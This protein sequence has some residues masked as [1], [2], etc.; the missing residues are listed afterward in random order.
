MSSKVKHAPSRPRAL[1]AAADPELHQP[2]RLYASLVNSLGG[3]VW[4]ADGRTFQFSFVSPQAEEILGY[5]VAQ[6]L[7][8]PDFWV[9]HTYPEDVERCVAFCLEATARGADHKFEYRMIAADGR[10][11]WLHD[12]VTVHT[13]PDGALRLRGIMIDIT[14]RKRVEQ[15]HDERLRF[16]T[17]LTELSATFAH[18]PAHA[19]D[20]EIDRWLRRLIDFLGVDRATL[21]QIG[22]DGQFQRTHTYTAPGIESLPAAPF[23]EQFPWIAEQLRQGHTI[24]WAR[25]PADLPPEARAERRYALKVGAKS[26][27]SIPISIGGVHI[28]ALSFTSLCTY[29]DWPVELVARLRLVGE[30]FANALERRRVEEALRESEARFRRLYN[31]NVVG[32]ALGNFDGR[33]YDANDEYLRIVGRTRADLEAG[34][35][36]WWSYTAPE[37]RR[38]ERRALSELIHTG[39]HAPFEKAYVRPDGTRVPALIGSAY[40]GGNP[41]RRFSMVI[42][43]T[44]YKRTEQQ[45]AERESFLRT[46]IEAEPE[47]VTLLAA[48][49]RVLEI[50]PAGLAMIEADDR[51]QVIGHDV[52]ELVAPDYREQFRALTAGAFRGK[53][54]TLEFELIGLKGTRRTLETHA[55]PLRNGGAEVTVMLAVT[56]DVSERKRA[57]AAL[58]ESEELLRTVAENIPAGIAIYNDDGLAYVNPACEVLTGYTRAELFEIDVWDIVHPEVRETGRSA[59]KARLKGGVPPPFEFPLVTKTGAVRWVYVHNSELMFRGKRSILAAVIDLTERRQAE[60]A[61]RE[62]EARFRQLAEN[63]REVFWM[64][65]PGYGET[66]YVSPAYESIWGRSRESLY[67]EPRSFMDAIHLEDRARAIDALMHERGRPF[68]L[69]YRIVKPD[70]GVRWIRDRGFPITDAAG[71]VYRV[72]GIAE[73]ITERKHAEEQLRETS[74]QLRAL[75]AGLRATR[76]AEG[77]RIARELHDELGSALTSL[78]WDLEWLDKRLAEL[79]EHTSPEALRLKIEAMLQ[80]ADATINAVRR[81]SSE[82]RPS[83]LDDL[84][85]VEAIEWQAQQFE[86]RTGITCHCDCQLE[87]LD[88]DPEPA[89]AVFRIFQEALTNVMRHAHATRVEITMAEHDDTFVLRVSDDGRGITEREKSGPHSLGLL[90][91]RERAHLVGGCVEITGRADAGTTVTIYVPHAR[92]A[93]AAQTNVASERNA[94]D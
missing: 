47:C 62:S 49:G 92:A 88:L 37:D 71:K 84:G 43:L 38:L 15:A 65:T 86:A 48:D 36:N 69:E 94:A 59:V 60:G 28:C 18:V 64:S 13:E 70:G 75:M 44:A 14:E 53:A 11:V 51:A 78:R 73:D 3:I 66:L 39:R 32:M 26:G 57:E 20:Q 31:A 24:N 22:T 63:I 82:L 2:E 87:Q 12:I 89:T 46:I 29:R 90:G 74:R 42:D 19:V 27:L 16:E 80:L 83:I 76:E 67:R 72:A 91:M 40:L 50:N 93:A 41:P 23:N 1:H 52:S 58:R 54:G 45:L 34:Q 8:E 10:I 35:L 33:I 56:R 6:W 7:A 68:E 17:L 9:R 30:V 79:N 21:F 61:L 85:L 4:E 25:I 77:V 81:I 5:P 55:V